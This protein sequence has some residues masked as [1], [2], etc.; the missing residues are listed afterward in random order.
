MLYFHKLKNGK[1]TS[2]MRVNIVLLNVSIV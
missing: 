1:D 2:I